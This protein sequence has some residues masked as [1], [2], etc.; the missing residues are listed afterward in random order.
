MYIASISPTWS[1]QKSRDTINFVLVYVTTYFIFLLHPLSSISSYHHIP[2]PLL[3]ARATGGRRTR[4][5]RGGAPSIRLRDSALANVRGM[6]VVLVLILVVGFSVHAHDKERRVISSY[7][8]YK[9]M[10]LLRTDIV[11]GTLVMISI[12][13]CLRG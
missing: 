11:V 4:R 8:G 9:L 13:S 2:F 3:D 1:Q 6:L 7:Q 12:S 10:F 5:L